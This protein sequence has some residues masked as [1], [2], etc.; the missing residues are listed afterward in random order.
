M[1]V[2][3]VTVEVDAVE[4]RLV[5]RL[6]MKPD[7]ESGLVMP[8]K[9]LSERGLDSDREVDDCWRTLT[10]GVP[11]LLGSLSCSGF[12]ARERVLGLLLSPP[13]MIRGIVESA[14]SA[15]LATGLDS[16]SKPMEE[17]RGRVLCL[18]GPIGALIAG[19]RRNE[20]RGVGRREARRRWSIFDF[21]WRRCGV[22]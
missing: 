22:L 15:T 9:T 21:S 16:S 8:A 13:K 2:P 7:R 19:R 5:R 12:V 18:T 11:G 10:T 4:E 3:F 17:D 20:N 14:T 1:F 6:G